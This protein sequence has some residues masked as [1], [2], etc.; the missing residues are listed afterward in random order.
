MKRRL[1]VLGVT[2][3]LGTGVAVGFVLPT[4][5]GATV[6]GLNAN[7]PDPTIALAQAQA[8]AP[9]TIKQPTFLPAGASLFL[10]N[11]LAPNKA[12]GEDAFAVDIWYSLPDGSRLHLWQ[13][14]DQHLTAEGKD[15]AASDVGQPVVLGGVTWREVQLD[16]SGGTA[17]SSH[18]N[19]GITVSLDGSLDDAT[20][21]QV[22]AS[23]A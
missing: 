20:L 13:T 23:I 2:V 12:E 9:Y 10:V 16:N 4:G 8:A 18:F 17:L 3:A 7:L 19:D 6:V 15:P 22:A 14:N 1:L 21:R 5:V 11:W